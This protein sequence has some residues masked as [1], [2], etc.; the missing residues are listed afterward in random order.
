MGNE[1]YSRQK[2]IVPADRLAECKVTVIGIGAIG[3]QAA[4]QLAAV[5]I[6]WLQLIDFDTVEESN[7]ASQGYFEQ[8]LNRLKVDAA[9]DLCRNINSSL[10]IQKVPERFR[11]SINIG[12]VVFCCVDSVDIRRLIWEAVRDKSRI[13]I[14]GRMAAESLRVLAAF[15]SKSR[16]YYPG[17]LFSTEEAYAGPCT[18]KTTIYCANIAAG[19]MIIQFTKYLRQLPVD[20]DIQ[21]NLLASELSVT[22][23]G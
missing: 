23:T 3:R 20:C 16:R 7:I 4:L 9:A 19:L 6:S 8:D 17:T 5:G 21:L 18:A 15:D 14:D 12:D 11:R 2:D 1:R 13:F 22:E 10:E